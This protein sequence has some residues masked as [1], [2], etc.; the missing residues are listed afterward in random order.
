MMRPKRKGTDVK[1]QTIRNEKC[2]PPNAKVE[3]I[4]RESDIAQQSAH[5][6]LAR[7]QKTLEG[8]RKKLDGRLN[9]DAAEDKIEAED[10][11]VSS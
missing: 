8:L 5:D 9:G 7:V 4:F 11:A 1:A 2:T 6:E 10:E 3:E